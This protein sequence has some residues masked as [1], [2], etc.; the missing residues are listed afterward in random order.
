MITNPCPVQLPPSP[1]QWVRAWAV[2]QAE[3]FFNMFIV[4]III[5]YNIQL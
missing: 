5:F 1:S 4:N 2:D 3:P